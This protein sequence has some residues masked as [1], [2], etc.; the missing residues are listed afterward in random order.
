M[1]RQIFERAIAICKEPGVLTFAYVF[2]KPEGLTEE[3]AIEDAVATIRY[4]HGLGVNEVALSCAFVQ[5]GTS[6]CQSYRKGNF[7]PPKLWSVI[8]VVESTGLLMSVA[9][10]GFS[11]EPPPI[12]VPSNCPDCNQVVM[13]AIQ[14]YRENH[15]LS[16]FDGLQCDCK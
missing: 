6:L 1:S 3:E 16:A 8:K 10:G 2:L 13:A 9:I 7:Q 5:E 12:A 11:D 15:Q 14:T 4:C